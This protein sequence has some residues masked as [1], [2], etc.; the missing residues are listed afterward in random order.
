MALIRWNSPFRDMETLQREMNRLF[1]RMIPSD[2]GEVVNISGMT[3]VPAAEIQETPDEIKLRMEVPGIDAK[4]LDVRISAE[5]VAISGERKSEVKSDDKGMHRSE[6]RYGSFQRI[7]PL[8]TRIQNDKV[9]AEFKNGVLC[10]MLPKAEEEKNRVVTLNLA[11][12]SNPVSGQINAHSQ[13]ELTSQ[14]AHNGQSESK[15][16]QIGS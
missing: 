4:D 3:F 11:E 14:P 16:A 10:L 2:S 8:P 13:S 6:F 9:Q 15:P 7:I 5:A 1:D 12:Q